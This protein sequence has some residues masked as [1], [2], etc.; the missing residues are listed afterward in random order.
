MYLSG[1]HWRRAG[2]LDKINIKFCNTGGAIFGVKAFVPALMEYVERYNAE[3]NF[4]EQLVK[5]DGPNQTAWF[6]KTDADG[7]KNQVA[8]WSASLTCYMCARLNPLLTL[9]KPAHSPMKRV[10][11]MLIST[12]CSTIQL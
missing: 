3:L 11:L 8:K 1:D 2:V 7:N 12:L 10:G 9:L 6:E 4:G 5:V